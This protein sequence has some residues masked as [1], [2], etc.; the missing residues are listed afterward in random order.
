MQVS[1]Q[2]A[3]GEEV[4]ILGISFMLMGFG[5]N[6]EF[7]IG[8]LFERLTFLKRPGP[9]NLGTVVRG[10]RTKT[11]RIPFLCFQKGATLTIVIGSS[12]LFHRWLLFFRNCGSEG[13]TDCPSYQILCRIIW[14]RARYEYWWSLG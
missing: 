7:A 1:E 13:Y 14:I 5:R 2:F 10:L 8:Q 3:V 9:F 11:C 12:T 6:L 4:G